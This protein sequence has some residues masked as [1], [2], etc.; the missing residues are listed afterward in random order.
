VINTKAL[1]MVTRRFIV[2]VRKIYLGT[3]FELMN[4]QVQTSSHCPK[5][6]LDITLLQEGIPMKKFHHHT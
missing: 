5:I 3:S 6:E 4:Y 2:N 1:A